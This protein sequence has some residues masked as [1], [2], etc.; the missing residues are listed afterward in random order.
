MIL[1]LYLEGFEIQS[2]YFFF[3]LKT[4]L[5]VVCKLCYAKYLLLAVQVGI[6]LSL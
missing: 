1:I 2:E 6:K 4:N 5:I 3:L